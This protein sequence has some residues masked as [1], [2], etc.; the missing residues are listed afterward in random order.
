MRMLVEMRLVEVS[1]GMCFY[2]IGR[3]ARMEREA[4]LLYAAGRTRAM[5]VCSRRVA[6]FRLARAGRGERCQMRA[7]RFVMTVLRGVHL[8][9]V[10]IARG[11]MS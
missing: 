9:R 3:V 11:F 8:Q 2:P 4:R 1:F 5:W 10:R 6:C 7:V